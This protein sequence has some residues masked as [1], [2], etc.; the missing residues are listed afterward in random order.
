MSDG[1]VDSIS[2]ET[3]S[4]LLDHLASRKRRTSPRTQSMSTNLSLLVVI[5]AGLT[6]LSGCGQSSPTGISVK[7]TVTADNALLTEGL[8]TLIP[9]AETSGHKCSVQI[10][11][12]KYTFERAHGLMPGE[13]RVEVMGLSPGIKAMAEGKTPSHSPSSYREIASA[14]NEK[15]TL[16]ITLQATGENTADFAV[17]YGK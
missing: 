10:L 17:K 13:Y 14:F 5:C 11:D 4:I 15:S 1:S 6:A 2:D 9:V 16:K 7:G 8:I 12:G 3:D